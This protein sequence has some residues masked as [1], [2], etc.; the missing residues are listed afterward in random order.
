MKTCRMDRK[1]K[2]V[3]KEEKWRKTKKKGKQF[4]QRIWIG[5]DYQHESKQAEESEWE[6]EWKW[7]IGKKEG[8]IAEGMHGR[9]WMIKITVWYD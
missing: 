5:K 6:G 9:G 2:N 7:G 4:E 3:I 1:N 8:E